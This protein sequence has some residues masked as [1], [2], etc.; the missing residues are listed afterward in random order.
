VL[1]LPD[2]DAGSLRVGVSVPGDLATEA[3]ATD[4]LDRVLAVTGGRGGGSA[5]FAQG[6]GSFP[7]GDRAA[8]DD[9][10]GVAS[11]IW[12]SLAEELSIS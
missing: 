9:L 3:P 8:G 7:R 1:L 4:V 2:P 12:T 5:S 11:R 6:G 10:S